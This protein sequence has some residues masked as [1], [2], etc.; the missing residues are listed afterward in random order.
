MTS[1]ASTEGVSGR[2]QVSLVTMGSRHAETCDGVSLEVELDEHGRLLS[3]DPAVVAR[4]DGHNLWRF[5]LYTAAVGIL[6][7]DSSASKKPDV[8]VHAQFRPDDRFHIDRPPE[9]RRVDHAL[10]AGRARAPNLE[11][12]MTNAAAYGTFQGCHQGVI[13]P[14]RLPGGLAPPVCA[15][16]P[17]ALSRCFSF[18]HKTS[19]GRWTPDANTTP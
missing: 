14:P 6:D 12:D 9:S 1:P 8:R 16:F 13:R 17:G 18:R 19:L 7:V 3:Y 5:A 15:D 4:I 11:L 2:G 10:H